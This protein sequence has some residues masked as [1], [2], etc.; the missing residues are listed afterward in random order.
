MHTQKRALVVLATM[1]V[2]VVLAS[3]ACTM[4]LPPQVSSTGT[5]E[6]QITVAPPDKEE[7]TPAVA[8]ISTVSDAEAPPTEPAPMENVEVQ[9][10]ASSLSE[11]E[12]AGLLY[13]REEEKLAHDVYLTLYQAWDLSIFRNIASSEQKH[14]DAVRSLLERYGI[15]DPAAEQEIGLFTN[16]E[17]Q[18][19]YNEL[20][21]AGSQSITGALRV[22]A[23]IEEI[24]ILDLEKYLAQTQQEDIRQV[25]ENLMAGSHN[26]LRAFVSTLERKTGETYEPQILSEE[27]FEA[28][29][30]QL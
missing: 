26:H 19:L 13:M 7:N 18:T 8:N 15:D 11:A 23:T 27:T 17:L 3:T 12:I 14:T 10:P 1:F 2:V 25:Y 28:I 30:A 24:D 29:L 9:Y 22:G 16:S 20:V 4:T 6:A 5:V 21:D